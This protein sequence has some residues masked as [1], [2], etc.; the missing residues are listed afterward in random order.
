MI[1]NNSFSLKAYYSL[2]PFPGSVAFN[3]P[4]MHYKGFQ[5]ISSNFYLG[6]FQTKVNF[7]LQSYQDLIINQHLTYNINSCNPFNVTNSSISCFNFPLNIYDFIPNN[8]A[9][10]GNQNVIININS[11]IYPFLY[12]LE[13][14]SAYQPCEVDTEFI[15][16]YI[17]KPIYNTSC[18]YLNNKKYDSFEFVVL[19]ENYYFD[20][21]TNTCLDP[22]TWSIWQ[23]LTVLFTCLFVLLFLILICNF[24][25]R[26]SNMIK[27]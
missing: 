7:M 8:C 12:T 20:Y 21:D 3:C 5:S 27:I 6:S 22:T 23:I 25:C 14:A 26:S 16:G 24:I 15:C 10:I 9:L 13:N 11:S 18:C 1:N 19:K 4:P 2:S 17:V